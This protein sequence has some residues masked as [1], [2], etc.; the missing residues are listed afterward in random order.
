MLLEC[1]AM[2]AFLSNF[3]LPKIF[4]AS[5]FRVWILSFENMQLYFG[6]NADKL[7]NIENY[8]LQVIKV[9]LEC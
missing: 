9:S 2:T 3:N 8:S 6:E 4:R 5:D 1:N 7:N